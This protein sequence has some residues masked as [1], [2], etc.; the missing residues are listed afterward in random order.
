[1]NYIEQSLVLWI[2]FRK[3][4]Y[5]ISNKICI[6]LLQ[7]FHDI[8]VIPALRRVASSNN[9]IASKLCIQALRTIGEEIPAKL[10]F[11]ISCWS[12]KEVQMWV[13][14]IG[15]VNF[16]PAFERHKVDGDLLLT[17]TEAELQLDIEM[18]S[19]LLKRRYGFVR[20]ICIFLNM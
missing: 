7:V 11:N 18:D 10:S 3:K 9:E 4:T 14:N 13:K 5:N 20:L 2:I 12:V 19:S 8:L 16:C 1:M 6:F 17:I 15:F